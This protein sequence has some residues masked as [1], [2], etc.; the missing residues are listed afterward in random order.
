MHKD[1][2]NWPQASLSKVVLHERKPLLV[3]LELLRMRVR[4]LRSG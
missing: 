1:A 3:S 4:A 2:V